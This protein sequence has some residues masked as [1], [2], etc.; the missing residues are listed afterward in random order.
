MQ[1][2]PGCKPVSRYFNRAH[3]R[4]WRGEYFNEDLHTHTHCRLN[5]LE[6][7]KDD[8]DVALHI[9][10]IERPEKQFDNQ[11]TL[12]DLKQPRGKTGDHIESSRYV[13]TASSRPTGPNDKRV[14]ERGN[15]SGRC[16]A[17]N[18]ST[19]RAS[20]VDEFVWHQQDYFVF[21]PKCQKICQIKCQKICHIECQKECQID[22]PNRMSEDKDTGQDLL[23][24]SQIYR[25]VRVWML[26]N[27]PTGP[28]E[29][30]VSETGN[31]S[32]WMR[33]KKFINSKGL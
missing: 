9:P 33:G 31:A 12:F 28:D 30:R 11:L 25:Y 22:M 29:K 7:E 19:V 17:R 23:T 27:V 15:D 21:M 6:E 3:C 2:L 32:G 26:A 10:E 13:K 16:A 5:D 18:L 14:S 20:N 4:F 1:P 24:P 8:F